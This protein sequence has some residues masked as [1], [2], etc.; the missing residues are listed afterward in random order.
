MDGENLLNVTQV[1]M[2]IGSSIQTISSWYR[3]RDL[4]P[5]HELA[6]LIPDYTRIGN[7]RTRYWKQADVW[8]LLE[9]KKRIPQGRYGVMGD[10]TQCYVRKKK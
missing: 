6:R 2:L 8:S 1:S 10:V 5:E 9:F 4:H 7:K 3:W